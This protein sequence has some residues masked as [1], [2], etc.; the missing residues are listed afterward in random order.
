MTSPMTIM[1][2]RPP[3]PQ[4][5]CYGVDTSAEGGYRIANPRLD[6]PQS[7]TVK[8]RTVSRV[9][10][11]Q[12]ISAISASDLPVTGRHSKTSFPSISAF[13]A[14][15]LTVD[16]VGLLALLALLAVRGAGTT[17]RPSAKSGGSSASNHRRG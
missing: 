16:S 1:R 13:S 3:P 14:T 5:R 2:K 10:Y 7:E 11:L 17:P 8:P 12:G 6:C 9:K 4:L 15:V